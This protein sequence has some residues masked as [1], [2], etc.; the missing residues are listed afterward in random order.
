VASAAATTST[1]GASATA[2]TSTPGT[3]ATATTS[4]PGTPATATT[5]SPAAAS[6]AAAPA[7]AWRLRG[8]SE[9][10]AASRTKSHTGAR[11]PGRLSRAVSGPR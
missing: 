6:G 8:G 11:P 9:G 3:P 10:A 1:A 5:A 7:P 4:T 2:T